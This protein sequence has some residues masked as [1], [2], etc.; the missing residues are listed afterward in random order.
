M[1][2]LIIRVRGLRGMLRDDG[3]YNEM[4]SEGAFAG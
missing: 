4:H 2:V 3:G 1:S